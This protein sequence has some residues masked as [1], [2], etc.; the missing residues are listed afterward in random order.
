MQE[1]STNESTSR[2]LCSAHWTSVPASCWTKHDPYQHITR[3][4][5]FIDT[6]PLHWL[7]GA[8]MQSAFE[9]IAAARATEHLHCSNFAGRFQTRPE[10]L[11]AG[12]HILSNTLT[13]LDVSGIG[14][15]PRALPARAGTR[16]TSFRLGAQTRIGLRSGRHAD[17]AG[18]LTQLGDNSL[19]ST[20]IFPSPP[21]LQISSAHCGRPG[22]GSR[23]ARGL[24]GRKSSRC[25]WA[26]GRA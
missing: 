26:S 15:S 7:G 19:A 22:Y 11:S 14:A 6:R 12:I 23:Y 16:D 17:C 5:P 2:R 1:A 9:L 21:A 8:R 25:R 3:R 10:P 4:T 18:C 24:Q 13:A 20:D